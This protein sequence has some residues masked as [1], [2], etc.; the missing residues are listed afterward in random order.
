MNRVRLLR[1]VHEGGATRTRAQ[2]TR[3]LEL[4]RGT[5]SVLVG[6]LAAASLLIESPAAEH[7]RGRPTMVPGAHPGGPQALAVDLREDEWEIAVCELGGAARTV[8]T[9]AHDR[10]PE[11]ALHP[12]GQVLRTL[13]TGRT[14]GVGL[15]IAGPVRQGERVDIAHL[16]WREVDVAGLLGL[17]ATP[18]TVGNDARLA[19]LAEARRGALRGT[20][21]GLH[22]HVAFD[23]GGSLLIDGWPVTGATGRAGEYGHMPLVPGDEP[24]LCGATGCWSLQV[25]ANALLR[26][27][28]LPYGQGHGRAEAEQVL[29]RTDA[30][31]RRAVERVASALGSGIGAL[32]NA[33]DPD[34]VSVSGFGGDLLEPGSFRT[35]YLRA[36]MGMHR[37]APARVVA[38]ELGWRGPLIGAMESVFD[39]FLT[40]GRVEAWRHARMQSVM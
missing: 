39:G 23:P 12:L 36:L 6:E 10:T 31:A 18:L 7:G 15:A 13:V 35:A 2:L 29:S 34:L 30:P 3:D 27:L 8:E 9:R 11:G 22:L 20:K 28:G 1:A 32:V 16:G 4:A 40:P 19:G 17:G 14:V 5:A 25:G 37:E 38:S 21:V 33:H 26:H 24:C